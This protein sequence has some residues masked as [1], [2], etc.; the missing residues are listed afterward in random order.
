MEKKKINILRI[1]AYSL[2]LC[3]LTV[4][5]FSVTEVLFER[6]ARAVG[7]KT[8]TTKNALWL[9]SFAENF[10]LLPVLLAALGLLYVKGNEDVRAVYYKEKKIITLIAAA[11]LYFAFLPYFAYHNSAAN[12]DG[13]MALGD[14]V[15]WFIWQAIALT[16]LFV[17]YS[18]RQ[19]KL[20]GRGE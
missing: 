16:V 10:T 18:D 9:I 1:V 14:R 6:L 5:V 15:I 17:Y 4:A 12:I 2:I 20:E 8:D 7:E 11:F 19:N 3:V 13:F